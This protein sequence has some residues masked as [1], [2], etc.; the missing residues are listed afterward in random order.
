MADVAKRR[1]RGSRSSDSDVRQPHQASLFEAAPSSGLGGASPRTG[2]ALADGTLSYSSPGSTD[3]TGH[4][5]VAD[6]YT[7][8]ALAHLAAPAAPHPA[9]PSGT[10]SNWH[11]G[12]LPPDGRSSEASSKKSAQ[13]VGTRARSRPIPSDMEREA[14]LHQESTDHRIAQVSSQAHHP[15]TAESPRLGFYAIRRL[16][17][18]LG[19][20]QDA[21]NASGSNDGAPV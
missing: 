19:G 15:P 1:G 8:A 16:R 10:A 6:G 14:V 13:V 7:V 4:P 18:I 20:L 9:S 3:N 11:P 21:V 5:V 17:R 2:S 12:F